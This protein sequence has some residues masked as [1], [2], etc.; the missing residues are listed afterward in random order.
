[1]ALPPCHMMCQFY[2]DESTSELSCQ[3]YQRSADLFLGVPFNIASY[4]LLTHI[5]AKI[6]GLTA[7][8][9]N[10]VFGDAH[11]YKTHLDAV[12]TQI[13]RSPFDFPTISIH[14]DI[15]NVSDLSGL[16]FEDIELNSYKCHASIFAPMSV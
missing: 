8:R 9:L 10:I 15:S 6:V 16:S 12:K 4:A 2:V 14:K 3:L 11:I 7:S 13:T 1:M 5:I